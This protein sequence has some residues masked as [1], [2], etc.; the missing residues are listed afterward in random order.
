M[1]L[2]SGKPVADQ[3]HAEIRERIGQLSLCPGLAVVLVGND[4]ASHLYVGLKER[5]ATAD[6]MHFEKHIFAETDT[7][8]AVI[9]RIAALNRNEAIHGIIV[10]LP[11]PRGFDTDRVIA[12]LDPEKDADGFHRD[13][14][15]A[16]LGGERAKIPVFPEA[17][18]ELLKSSGE[19]LLG[20]RSV[21]VAHSEYFGSVLARACRDIGME[22][23]ILLTP[24]SDEDKAILRT[25]QVILTATGIPK[26]ID[27]SCIAPGSIII[28]G[29]IAKEDGQVV[30]DVDAESVSAE[31]GFLSPVP[32]G[33]GPVTIA[34]LLRRVVAFLEAKKKSA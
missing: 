33:V 9:D 18:L 1:Q 19:P 17:L 28:D 32:G 8:A 26:S 4:P 12:A 30:G 34:C 10:Q 25:A 21:V 27:G 11:L 23:E 16:F 14:V 7:E 31:A 5:A 20:R 3:I 15:A 13:N 22:V 29:G 2:L 24:V 6:G